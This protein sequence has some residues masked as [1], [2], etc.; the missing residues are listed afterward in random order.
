MRSVVHMT[1]SKR[2]G[3][4]VVLF[5]VVALGG[6]GLAAT[7]QA[8]PDRTTR[9]AGAI[10]G[11]IGAPVR[12]ISVNGGHVTVAVDGSDP[13]SVVRGQWFAGVAASLLAAQSPGPADVST[14]APDSADPAADVNSFTGRGGLS[15][16]SPE[17]PSTASGLAGLKAR[18]A[19]LGA[20]IAG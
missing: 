12:S 15:T 19:S 14:V 8:G 3:T 7:G 2:R 6:I 13:A 1:V 16:G 20:S 18:A 5:S 10:V 17:T 11:Q 4:L 9:R